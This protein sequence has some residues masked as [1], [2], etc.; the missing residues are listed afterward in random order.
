MNSSDSAL[1][2]GEAIHKLVEEIKGVRIAMLTTRAANGELHSRP[3]ATQDQDFQGELWFFT[4]F[5]SGKSEEL[6][7]N[8]QVNVAYVDPSS[9][10]YV[11]VS[12]AA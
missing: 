2:R 10:R 9:N 12:K 1:S 4:A 11:S 7:A 8:P 5:D 3:M 6:I